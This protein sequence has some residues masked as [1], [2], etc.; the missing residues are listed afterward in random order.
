MAMTVRELSDVELPCWVTELDTPT[1]PWHAVVAVAD[2][3]RLIR[4]DDGIELPAIP[5]A[6]L[7]VALDTRPRRIGRGRRVSIVEDA[8]D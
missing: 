6:F 7:L 1:G 4:L 8:D 2:G 5:D 3:A